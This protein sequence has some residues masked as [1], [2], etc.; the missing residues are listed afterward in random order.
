MEQAQD[1]QVLLEVK[2]L[3][4]QF[5]LINGKEV[6]VVDDVSFVIYK[7]ET[8]ALVGE[9]GSGKEYNIAVNH[10]LAS[11]ASWR[12]IRRFHYIKR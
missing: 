4:V 9:S 7:G 6:K 5:H 3:H 1:R 2:Q 12:N 10:A 11:D 8:V